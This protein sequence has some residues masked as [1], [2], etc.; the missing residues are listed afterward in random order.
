MQQFSLNVN[1]LMRRFSFSYVLNR[2]TSVFFLLFLLLEGTLCRS[3]TIS[4]QIHK[5]TVDTICNRLQ[6]YYIFPDK[7]TIMCGLI[8]KKLEGGSYNNLKDANE[9]AKS[10]TKDLQSVNNDKHIVVYFSPEEAKRLT[11]KQKDTAQLSLLHMDM[12]QWER[13]W[14][15]GFRTVQIIE[16]NIGYIDLQAFT[17]FGEEAKETLA[18]SMQFL[19]N[20]DAMIID[21][22]KNFGGSPKM[23]ALVA[24]YF[25][26]KGIHLNSIYSSITK[27][28]AK[29]YTATMLPGKRRTEVPLYILIGKNT[30]SGEKS[31]ATT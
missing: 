25:L 21:M 17:E 24:S 15:F 28:T 31:L 22:R 1:C 5:A 18:S 14:N 10:I 26:E 8:Q 19:E 11:E 30:I 4:S 27:D 2:L 3:Q 29:T 12:L 13:K 16:G 7:A 20:T 23:V 6:S 9:F